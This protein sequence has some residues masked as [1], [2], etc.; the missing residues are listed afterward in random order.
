MKR[1]Q[2]AFAF[3]EQARED[4]RIRYYGMAT[5]T[6]F[7]SLIQDSAD[8]ASDYLSLE[9]VVKLAESVG[10]TNHGF[11]F[12]QAPY[13]SVMT[14]LADLENQPYSKAPAGAPL[15]STVE[16]AQELGIQI[17]ASVPLLQGKL[18]TY[19]SLSPFKDLQTPAQQSLQFVRTT[20]GILAPLVGHKHPEHVAENLKVAQVSP[21][22]DVSLVASLQ[23]TTTATKA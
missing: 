11:R 17:F 6:C 19:S 22:E 10:G 20:P 23:T 18:L 7:R 1:L 12:I 8:P 3:Y 16:V 4:G 13:N 14:E 2:Q 21:N 15:L 5:W 9:T